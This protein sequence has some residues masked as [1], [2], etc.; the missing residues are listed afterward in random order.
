VQS[1]LSKNDL[2]VVLIYLAT[3]YM[4]IH[5]KLIIIKTFLMRMLT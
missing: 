4:P 5:N 3:Y 2:T 1:N